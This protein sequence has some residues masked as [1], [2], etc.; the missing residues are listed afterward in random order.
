MLLLRSKISSN[1]EDLNELHKGRWWIPDETMIR[2]QKDV[3]DSKREF[4]RNILTKWGSFRDF[5]L[6]T[7]FRYPVNKYNNLLIVND[8]KKEEWNFRASLFPYNLAADVNHYILW[9]SKYDCFTEFDEIKINGII[10]ECLSSMLD[11]DKF[12]FAWYLNPKPSI[13]ELWH[14]QVFWIRI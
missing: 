14:C 2:P 1:T 11:S 12:D 9:N 4:S 10:K 8:V 13:S 5:I 7:H 6:D 3:L